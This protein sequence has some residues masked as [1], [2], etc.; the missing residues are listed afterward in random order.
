MT[1]TR[2]KTRAAK[3]TR[4]VGAPLKISDQ[5]IQDILIQYR[6]EILSPEARFIVANKMGAPVS[7]KMP[8]LERA[9]LRCGLT[10]QY[11]YERCCAKHDNGDIRNAELS[12]TYNALKTAI[13]MVWLEAGLCKAVDSRA[14]QFALQGNRMYEVEEAQ[15]TT[16]NL[17]Q[18][19]LVAQ[20][21]EL[22]QAYEE[23]LADLRLEKEAMRQRRLAMYEQ[24][25]VIDA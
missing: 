20:Q 7:F 10:R 15:S 16:I 25:G 17:Q 3:K 6:D 24:S 8:T 11:L 14:M 21:A 5:D 23:V 2:K 9:A 13:G 22:D 12:D 4:A 18:N 19:I 1:T